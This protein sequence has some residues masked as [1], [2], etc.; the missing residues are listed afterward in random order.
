M[1]EIKIHYPTRAWQLYGQNSDLW[2][3][4]DFGEMCESWDNTHEVNCWSEI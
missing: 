1:I 3:G 2:D 4:L